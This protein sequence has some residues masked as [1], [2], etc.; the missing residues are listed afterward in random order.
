MRCHH[1]FSFLDS[2]GAKFVYLVFW[3]TFH[4]SNFF[5]GV[6]FNSSSSE[7]RRA[8]WFSRL[9]IYLCYP[10]TWYCLL[11]V[12]TQLLSHCILGR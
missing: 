8:F 3:H 12:Y 4:D 5:V 2:T 11:Y 9:A 7:F 1:F 10:G 6:I